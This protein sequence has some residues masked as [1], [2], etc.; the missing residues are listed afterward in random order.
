MTFV[1][2]NPTT[3]AEIGR[4]DPTPPAAVERVLA[5]AVAAQRAWGQAAFAVRAEPLRRLGALLR[6]EADRL[7]ERMALEMGKPLAQ[8]RAEAE[9]CA[10]ACEYFADHAAGFLATQEVAEVPGARIAFRPLGV[11]LAV[12]PW[13]FPFWQVIRFAAPT[14]MAGNAGLLKHAP[15]VQGCAA[16][17]VDLFARAGFPP[18]LFAN[19]AVEVDGVA[20]LIARPEVG[21][22]T[23]TGSARAGR[24]VAAAAGAAL[25][26]SVL[27]LGGSDPYVVLEDADV[28]AAAATCVASRLTNA[29]QTCISAKRFIVVEPVREA[30]TDAVR[31]RLA[32]ARAGDPLGTG[33]DAPDLGPLARRDLRDALHDQV[34]RSVAAGARRVLGGEV[35][36]RAGWFYPPTL[37]DGVRPGMAA[38]DEETF[39]P[40]AAIVPA[41]DEAEAV[42]LANASEFGLG[43]AVFT[44]D[45]ERGRRLAELGLEA[46]CCVVNDFVRSDPRLP[47]GGIR[48]S[49]YGREL[50]LF[51]IRE[52]VNIKTVSVRP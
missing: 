14:L 12:M 20:A 27:E 46:G 50:G 44:A 28:G 10:W 34:R 7:A 49:G 25:K 41:R 3:E 40:V 4:T 52:F 18:G 26:K 17:L 32:A 48:G 29:G 5:A 6:A 23:L 21:A 15:N 42:A 30:F 35:P 24:A 22:V 43:A 1:S 31:A 11:V 51:G 39:G 47:F 38:F 16:D 9:K 2:I 33:P 36:G 19:L 13:N 37:L 8:G 45:P